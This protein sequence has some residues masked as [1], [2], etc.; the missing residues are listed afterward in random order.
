MYFVCPGY[1]M[2][3]RVSQTWRACLL[4]FKNIDELINC[5]ITECDIHSQSILLLDVEKER[6]ET[7]ISE[8]LPEYFCYKFNNL[9]ANEQRSSFSTEDITTE[10]LDRRLTEFIPSIP[11]L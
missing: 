4:L 11:S 7:K 6:E 3:P 9:S 10:N 5:A 2:L 8:T 1:R